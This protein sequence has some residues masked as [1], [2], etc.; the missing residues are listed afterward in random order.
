MGGEGVRKNKSAARHA[1][2]LLPAISGSCKT[3]AHSPVR[4]IS[5]FTVS[6]LPWLAFARCQGLFINHQPKV[7]T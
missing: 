2:G 1:A 6:R 7:S 4:S 5:P 3:A